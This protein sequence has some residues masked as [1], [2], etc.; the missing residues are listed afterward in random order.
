ML[1]KV[2][3]LNFFVKGADPY[4]LVLLTW[5]DNVSSVL[6]ISSQ[7]WQM[8]QSNVTQLF[9]PLIFQIWRDHVVVHILSRTFDNVGTGS[10]E[11][12]F[13][14]HQKIFPG[15]TWWNSQN[16]TIISKRMHLQFSEILSDSRQILSLKKDWR[17]SDNISSF[18]RFKFAK[19]N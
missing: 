19:F 6:M 15:Q 1:S 12:W 16:W 3:I 14:R 11:L 5:D 9:Q 2:L 4:C 7:S 10:V 18:F 13:R 8:T 17:N